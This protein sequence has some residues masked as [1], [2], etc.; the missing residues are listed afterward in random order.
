[1]A[2][3]KIDRKKAIIVGAVWSVAYF[4][5]I[6]YY[7][8]NDLGFN[9]L[10]PKDWETTYIAFMAGQ[11]A[12]EPDKLILLLLTLIL[13]VPVWLIGWKAFYSVNWKVPRFLLRQKEARFKRE[14]IIAPN[15]GKLQA[16]V[17]LRL[18]SSNPYSGL[19]K[20]DFGQLP[21]LP[22][23]PQDAR[24]VVSVV[25]KT[26]T[27][28]DVQDIIAYA[29]RYGIDTFKDVVLD[30]IKVPLAVSTDDKAILITLLDTPDATWIVDIT[31]EESE[32][33]CETSH[34][35]SPT[36]FIKKATD[37]LQALEPDSLVIPAVVITDGEIYDATDI[38]NHYEAMGI[39]ILRFK[40]GAP[41]S[42][43][44]LE[45]FIDAHFAA[46]SDII[47]DHEHYGSA[48]DM[49][50]TDDVLNEPY[51][52][53]AQNKEVDDYFEPGPQTSD[54][55]V[56]EDDNFDDTFFE[57]NSV[58]ETPFEG[59]INENDIE[60]EDIIE[61]GSGEN[62]RPR[63]NP[64]EETA[65]VETKEQTG[66][67]YFS[68]MIPQNYTDDDAFVLTKDLQLPEDGTEIQKN[69]KDVENETN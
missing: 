39:Q 47:P 14:L 61:N 68:D 63:N 3:K 50:G 6:L 62:I 30:G 34:I 5:F 53:Q 1:M 69:V 65:T 37:A 36:A 23:P 27:P 22:T 11:F 10:S 28:N 8:S 57:S 49:N 24:H 17:K 66:K 64:I 40:N 52:T 21:E 13:L 46:K 48:L 32:W 33:Y 38:A 59:N 56:Y 2:G 44:T 42:L 29:D 67:D 54:D 15:K 35:P 41:A 7:V 45:S 55:T 4:T 25:E 51:P 18:Q 9:L 60:A 16:P 58:K 43:K 31:D 26:T 20:E 12:I 19:K